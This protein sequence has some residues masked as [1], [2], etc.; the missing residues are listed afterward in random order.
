QVPPRQRK[1]W[2]ESRALQASKRVFG[3]YP[4]YGLGKDAQ[5]LFVPICAD[6]QISLRKGTVTAPIRARKSMRPGVTHP[7][8]GARRRE[9]MCWWGRRPNRCT[10]REG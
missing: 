4:V 6:V 9:V 2:G 8:R 10:N 1:D 5:A 7:L 3:R